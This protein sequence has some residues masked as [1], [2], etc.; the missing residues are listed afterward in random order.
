MNKKNIL[1]FVTIALLVYIALN[2]FTQT[3]TPAP[4]DTSKFSLKTNKQEYSQHEL[5][6]AIL[7]NNTDQ[8]ITIPTE[9]PNE[10]LDVYTSL[11]G[12]WKQQT[13]AATITCGD[14]NTENASI[15]IKPKEEYHISYN[16]W[17]HALFSEIGHYKIG[18]T[19]NVI[20]DGKPTTITLESAEFE[21]T[22]QGFFRTV[23]S[24]IFYQPIYNTLIFLTSI[25]PYHDFGFAII[26]LTIIIRTIL[27][28]PSQKALKAQRKLQE[29]QPKLSHIREKHKN[30]QEMIAKETMQIWKEHKV[31]P[32]GSCLPMLIQFPVLI[33]LFYVIQ[34]GLNPDNAYLL[35][36][37][38]KNFSL[39]SVNVNF[40]GILDLTKVNFLV[41]PLLVGGLQFLQ[42]KLAIMRKEKQTPH[43]PKSDKKEQ[44]SEMEMANQMMIYIM[45]V[46]IA[47][48]TASVPA[49]VGLYWIM[50][51]VYGIAQ[52]LIV[53]KQVE[54][55]KTKVEVLST[56]K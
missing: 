50:S 8:P 44:K 56:K 52:Q 55:E 43:Q 31:N 2:F 21:V 39:L 34:S 4:E 47:V 29:I 13:N 24:T 27:L 41:L 54:E 51:T 23:W 36:G 9:C 10:P 49:G 5:V 35:Y 12:T 7:K 18:T 16:S 46:M 17:N 45:P 6:T 38:L 11:D 42:M 28:F 14:S 33:A 19:L 22:P 40:L 30:N 20:E 37:N 32:L 26:V 53:N 1:N 25:L 15:T 48:F 3:N